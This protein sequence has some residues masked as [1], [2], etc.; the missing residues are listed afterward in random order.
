MSSWRD[1]PMLAVDSETTG[2]NPETARL[3]TVCLGLATSRGWAPSNWLFRQDEPIPAEATEIH[4]ITTEQANAEGTDL[5]DGLVAIVHDLYRAW[6]EGMAVVIYNAPYDLTVIDHELRRCGLPPLE[7][8]GPVIDPLVLD[9]ALDRWR[10]GSRKLVDVA[11]HYGIE[12][13]EAAHG[14]EADALAACRLAWKLGAKAVRLEDYS[15]TGDGTTWLALAGVS[16]ADLHRFQMEAYESQRLSFMAYKARKGE[17]VDD[18]ST[19]WP[20]RSLPGGAAEAVA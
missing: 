9:K 2:V 5:R 6:D 19:E 14:A 7:V 4:G 20:L 15:R 16:L 13:G 18:T 17:P 10:K 12:L 8:R 11:A 1:R 3:V